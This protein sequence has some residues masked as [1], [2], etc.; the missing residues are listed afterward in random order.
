MDEW[1][2][3]LLAHEVHGYEPFNI[4]VVDLITRFECVYQCP[5]WELYVLTG[6]S[7]N[8]TDL[9]TYEH[10]DGRWYRACLSDVDFRGLPADKSNGPSSPNM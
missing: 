1:F 3:P 9:F 7:S 6:R 2:P 8:S 10:P 4:L 5:S